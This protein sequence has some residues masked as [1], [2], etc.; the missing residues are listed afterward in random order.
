MNFPQTVL[1][2]ALPQAQFNM[3]DNG[4]ERS[5]FATITIYVSELS[6]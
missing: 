6:S 4:G 3:I 5:A 1:L 2:S